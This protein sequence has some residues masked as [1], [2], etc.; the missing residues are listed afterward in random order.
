MS[1]C[2]CDCD[3]SAPIV[4]SSTSKTHSN[5]HCKV[6]D[7]AALAPTPLM[8]WPQTLSRSGRPSFDLPCDYFTIHFQHHVTRAPCGH[9][10][11]VDF[12]F[13]SLAR[14]HRSYSIASKGLI[15]YSG[16]RVFKQLL[17]HLNKTF[18]A[19]SSILCVQSSQD[20][21]AMSSLFSFS[22]QPVQRRFEQ[23]S[24]RAYFSDASVLTFLSLIQI[25][26]TSLLPNSQARHSAALHL[27]APVRRN[28]RFPSLLVSTLL[29]LYSWL[30]QA[31]T[32][33][34][35]SRRQKF[36]QKVHQ[37][38]FCPP[39]ASHLASRF[40]SRFISTTS[41]CLRSSSSLTVSRPRPF[42]PFPLCL[43][44]LLLLP[45]S[46]PLLSFP[47][48]LLR[49]LLLPSPLLLQLD[50]LRFPS[51]RISPRQRTNNSS[52]RCNHCSWRESWPRT[53]LSTFSL[54]APPSGRI[55]LTS[56][57]V[58]ELKPLASKV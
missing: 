8:T 34:D 42:H 9:C 40:T 55:W 17:N 26:L 58:A 37:P 1:V 15:A 30:P 7:L 45:L 16:L 5:A 57:K 31:I 22:T 36:C 53:R 51:A 11:R 4:Q 50:Q 44:I 43:P 28:P 20:A 33:Y 14:V 38:P 13:F 47:R 56:S 54:P 6:V 32:L 18:P 10:P 3:Q 23:P 41:I 35:Q 24:R 12:P 39:F 29:Y 2:V 19:F 21:D 25:S 52:Q 49:L 46:L 48:L 27:A